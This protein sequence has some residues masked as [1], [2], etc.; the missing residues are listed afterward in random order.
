MTNQMLIV[1]RLRAGAADDVARLFAASDATELPHAL[2]VR[3][4]G[5]FQYH[6]LY[7]HLAE[8]TGEAREAVAAAQGREDFR[9]LSDSLSAFVEP[10]DPQTWRGPADAMARSFYA[11]TAD[12]GTR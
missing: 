6:D 9:R 2:G 8:F 12:G 3:G 7:F 4:R 1:A 5:L 10:F 11:W